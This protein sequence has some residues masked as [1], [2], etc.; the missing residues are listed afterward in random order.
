LEELG[1]E[2]RG[3]ELSE[4]NGLDVAGADAEVW[5]VQDWG[6]T[7]HLSVVDGQADH[8]DHEP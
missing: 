7:D 6:D 4:F 3:H 1:G 2:K 8:L 5:G